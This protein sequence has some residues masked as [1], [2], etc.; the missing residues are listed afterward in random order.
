MACLVQIGPGYVNVDQIQIVREATRHEQEGRGGAHTA[1]I[2]QND[3][4]FFVSGYITTVMEKLHKG[5][6]DCLKGKA[7]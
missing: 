1:I 3:V 5:E 4:K 7:P 6:E 2:L